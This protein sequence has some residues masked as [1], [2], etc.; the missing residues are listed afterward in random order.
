MTISVSVGEG[1]NYREF[2]FDTDCFVV[3]GQIEPPD[4]VKCKFL[5]VRVG[6]QYCEFRDVERNVYFSRESPHYYAK[7]Y[8]GKVVE[9]VALC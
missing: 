4:D 9:L 5:F 7:E 3:R 1:E 2:N 6:E 8:H